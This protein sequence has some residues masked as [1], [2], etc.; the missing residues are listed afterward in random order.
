[1]MNNQIKFGVKY[2]CQNSD[3]PHSIGLW[4]WALDKCNITFEQAVAIK[5]ERQELFPNNRYIIEPTGT[6]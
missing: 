6:V 3:I 2:H 4:E 1:M 5:N